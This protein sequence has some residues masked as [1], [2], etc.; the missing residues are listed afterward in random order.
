MQGATSKTK[1]DFVV[2]SLPGLEA[3]AFESLGTMHAGLMPTVQDASAADGML[4]FWMLNARSPQKQP[5]LVFWLNGGPGC[6]S[7]DGLMLENGPLIPMKDGTMQLRETGWWLDATVVY[8]DQPVGTGYSSPG[9]SGYAHSLVQV[10]DM[11]YGFVEQ[12]FAVFEDLVGADVYIAGESYAGQY[13]PY[14]AHKLLNV[15]SSAKGVTPKLK[16]QG[17]LIGNGWMDPK[18]QY[19]SFIPYAVENNLLS[20]SFL[21]E[22]KSYE[23]QCST[24]F[25]Q[26]TERIKMS[27]CDAIMNTVL[28]Q[29]KSMEN[30]NCINM[31]DIRLYDEHPEDGCGLL[32]WPPH[33]QDMKAYLSRAEVQTAVNVP[34]TG[35][36]T[37]WEE[38]DG[39]VHSA[40]AAVGDPPSYT[41]FPS[42][43]ERVPILL[44]NGDKD[45]ICNWYGIRDM[46]DNLQWN[47]AQGMQDSKKENW[48]LN[49]EL[50]GWYQ[51]AR[52]LTFVLKYNASHMMPV[53][54]PEA[55][56]DMLNRFIGA[57]DP[58]IK[59]GTLG[60]VSVPG[61]EGEEKQVP[62]ASVSIVSS[63]LPPAPIVTHK[64][65]GGAIVPQ[66]PV[67]STVAEVGP[68]PVAGDF[69]EIIDTGNSIESG[70][71]SVSYGRGVV[72]L[73]LVAASLGLC[74]FCMFSK[75]RGR[76]SA[77]NFFGNGAKNRQGSTAGHDWMELEATGDEEGTAIDDD[78]LDEMLELEAAGPSSRKRIQ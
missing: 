38:C 66:R 35:S 54:A 48:Y 57:V 73:F 58:V 70:E 31:Y 29:S 59:A 10:A 41:L 14:I 61:K 30:Q 67:T 72:F 19:M 23:F 64:P 77:W 56:T 47:G 50:Q 74:Y 21:S 37:A 40:L 46:V 45:L 32:A 43:L 33:V 28:Y 27:H 76:R 71:D 6:S 26:N 53:D 9:K 15:P 65:P 60:D 52:N 3:K 75:T 20:G 12:Y 4:F 11:F 22:A 68:V 8:V 25:D 49:N 63:D 44:F 7:M 17:L 69:D 42:L 16:I 13:I 36:N 2:K 62:A 51:S 39:S 24:N 18:R 78:E 1:A 55:S 34:N 5:K